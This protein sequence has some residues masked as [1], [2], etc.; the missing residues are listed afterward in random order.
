MYHITFIPLPTY[1]NLCHAGLTRPPLLFWS[2]DSAI[3]LAAETCSSCSS[4][5]CRLRAHF[6]NVCASC[7][8]ARVKFAK[9][10]RNVRT[11]IAFL[12]YSSAN[13]TFLTYAIFF[14]DAKMPI[15]S[16]L[17]NIKLRI[18]IN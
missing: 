17:L 7:S 4:R 12:S 5:I 1:I 10:F 14:R 9:M 18:N 13:A 6:F 8:R 3:H 16:I 15:R 11:K 2:T